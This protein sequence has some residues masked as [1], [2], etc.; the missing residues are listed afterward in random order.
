ML[1]R[2]V[3]SRLRT[4]EVENRTHYPASNTAAIITIPPNASRRAV[5][6]A[7]QWSYSDT[8]VGGR[9]AITRGGVAIFDVDITT[10][11]PGGYYFYKCGQVN[12]EVIITLSAGGAGITGKLQ[13]DVT[14]DAM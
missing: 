1:T 5:I 6:H 11:G 4:E 13:A 10:S 3:E 2:E 7:I 12:E 8:P 14:Q 9:L